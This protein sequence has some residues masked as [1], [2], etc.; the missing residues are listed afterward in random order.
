LQLF[1][2]PPNTCGGLFRDHF[3]KALGSFCSYIGISTTFVVELWGAILTVK[4]TWQKG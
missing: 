3:G 1:G 2:T 4:T